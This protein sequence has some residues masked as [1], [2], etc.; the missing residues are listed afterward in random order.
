M[1]KGVEVPRAYLVVV[2][3][4]LVVGLVGVLLLLRGDGQAAEGGVF[5]IVGFGMVDAE[6]GCD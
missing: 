6:L 2:R 5:E 4:L 1:G 3:P